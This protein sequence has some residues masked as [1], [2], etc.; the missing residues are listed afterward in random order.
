MDSNRS[1]QKDE[2]R[3]KEPLLE[4]LANTGR[5]GLSRGPRAAL[6]RDVRE[7]IARK[8]VPKQCRKLD[9]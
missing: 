8:L 3:L 6:R 5:G 2:Q 7:L 9:I 1:D 4:G